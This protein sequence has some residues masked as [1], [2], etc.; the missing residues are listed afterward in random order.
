M[1]SHTRISAGEL[2]GIIHKVREAVAEARNARAE[3]VCKQLQALCDLSPSG[4]VFVTA[5]DARLLRKWL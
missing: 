5:E 3:R 4:E 2:S 1:S